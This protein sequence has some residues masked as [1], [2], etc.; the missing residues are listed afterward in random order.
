MASQLYKKFKEKLLKAE[1]DFIDDT[2]K[3]VLIDTANYTVDIDNDEYL[4]DVPLIARVATSDALT[5]KTANS[6]IADADNVTFDTISSVS[7]ESFVLFKDTGDEATS[8]LISYHD[9]ATNLP[10][11]PLGVD[12]EIRWSPLGIFTI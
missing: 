1:L 7:I 3:V 2:I 12:I 6:G 4:S 11:V 9:D 5:G 8:P 10:I